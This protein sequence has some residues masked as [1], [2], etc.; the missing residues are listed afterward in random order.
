MCTIFHCKRSDLIEEKPDPVPEAEL[1]L[2]YVLADDELHIIKTFRLLDAPRQKTVVEFID[3]NYDAYM[4]EL[5]AE[6]E[7]QKK[8]C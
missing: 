8:I 3:F 1:D 7:A 2:A 6:R 4:R 5:A